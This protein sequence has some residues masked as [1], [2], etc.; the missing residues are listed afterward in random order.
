MKIT[1]LTIGSGTPDWFQ[2]I[3]EEY[4]EK[5]TRWVSLS[6]KRLKTKGLARAQAHEMRRLESDALL[7]ALERSDFVILF[8]EKGKSL[9]TAAFK[10][11]SLF[12]L[13]GGVKSLV[14]VVGGAYGAS[15]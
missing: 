3:S 4:E 5:I 12:Q 14:F 8:D 13:E 6:I 9:D 11:Q 2:K 7:T 10:K 1:L 15:E